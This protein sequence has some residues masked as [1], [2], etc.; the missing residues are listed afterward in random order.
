MGET[1]RHF[2]PLEAERRSSLGARLLD[3]ANSGGVNNRANFLLDLAYGYG[4]PEPSD[5]SANL[6]RQMREQILTDRGE[7][8]RRIAWRDVA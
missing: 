7:R 8:D 6:L 1:L 3:Y 2:L 4:L 5:A